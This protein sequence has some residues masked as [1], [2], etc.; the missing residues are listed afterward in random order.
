MPTKS[1]RFYPKN[2]RPFSF[3]P[4]KDRFSV[5]KFDDNMGEGLI[6]HTEFEPG[7]VVFSFTGEMTNEITQYT[8]QV[9]PGLHI[10]DPFVMGKVL[11]SCDPNTGCDME[12]LTFF[13]RKKINS[14]DIIT[15]DYEQTED[16]LFKAFICNCGS[17]DCRGYIEGKRADQQQ[18]MVMQSVGNSRL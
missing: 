15:M 3:E 7:Q 13:A 4:T 10:H 1:I 12:K 11:H 5:I 8:L 6:S 16:V 18:D 2:V 14:G 9:R 17:P